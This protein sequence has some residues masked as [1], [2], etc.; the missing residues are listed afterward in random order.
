MYYKFN[1]IGNKG[2]IK[3]VILSSYK[4]LR[5]ACTLRGDIILLDAIRLYRGKHSVHQLYFRIIELEMHKD[6]IF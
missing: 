3:E 4:L 1:I 5:I 2:T 6:V